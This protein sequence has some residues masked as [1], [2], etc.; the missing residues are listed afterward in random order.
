M[1]K[2]NVLI[3]GASY[4]SLFSTKLL[5]AGHNATL[6]CTKDTADLINRDGTIVRM[7]IKGREGLLDIPSS[8]LAGKLTASTPDAVDPAAFDLVVLGM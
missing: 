7:P 8:K 3:F 6:V 2:Y 4:G 1:P 5:M